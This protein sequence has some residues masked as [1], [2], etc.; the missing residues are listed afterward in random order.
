MSL[1]FSILFIIHCEHWQFSHICNSISC[2]FHLTIYIILSSRCVSSPS[3]I[4]I[5]KS[6]LKLKF[7]YF[8]HFE[9]LSRKII[10]MFFFF[11]HF[12]FLN[13]VVWWCFVCLCVCLLFNT[14][15]FFYQNV[16]LNVVHSWR[17]PCTRVLRLVLLKFVIHRNMSDR[18]REKIFLE[19]NLCKKKHV[20][21]H[22][23]GH[24]KPNW[25]GCCK[26]PNRI[27]ICCRW[28]SL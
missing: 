14:K 7:S 24:F 28:I 17:A 4:I 15:F 3:C 21:L 16:L 10:R 26:S 8:I 6:V 12:S 1:P 5:Q 9:S 22:R 11:L 19:R 20:F 27:W 23:N 25:R 2:S 18:K 13:S